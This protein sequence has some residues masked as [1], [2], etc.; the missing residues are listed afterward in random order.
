MTKRLSLKTQ[1]RIEFLLLL[2]G[3][4]KKLEKMPEFYYFFEHSIECFFSSNTVI[5]LTFHENKYTC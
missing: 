2:T 3:S 1:S 4:R 5:S